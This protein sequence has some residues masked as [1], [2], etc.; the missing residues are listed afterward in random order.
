L[1]ALDGHLVELILRVLG[2]AGV[3]GIV[4]VG[5]FMAAVREPSE[6]SMKPLRKPVWSMGSL[7]SW[8]ARILIQIGSGALKGSHSEMRRL[9][10]PSFSNSSKTRK[11]LPVAEVLHAGDAVGEGVGDGQFVAAAALVVAGRGNDLLDQAPAPIRA[12]CRWARR[13]RRDRWLRLAAE[14]FCR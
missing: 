8:W 6:P 5:S 11:I 3:A 1:R 2:Q 13:W 14:R 4:G 12:E 7:A 9:S 10:L